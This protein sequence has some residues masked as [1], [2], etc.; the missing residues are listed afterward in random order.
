MIVAAR[1]KPDRTGHLAR[2]I[3][4]IRLQMSN[5]FR[6]PD[7]IRHSPIYL[8]AIFFQGGTSDNRG[9]SN[10]FFLEFTRRG[11]F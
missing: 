8:S 3:L 6:N 2:E 10:N 9:T 11:G 5:P 4:S 7:G 1:N